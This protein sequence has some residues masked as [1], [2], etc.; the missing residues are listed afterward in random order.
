VEN[1]FRAYRPKPPV[2]EFVEVFWLYVGSRPAH[3]RERLLPMGTMEL[4][5]NLRE[6]EL[7]VGDK[8][9]VDRFRTYGRSLVSGV[10]TNYFVL[11]TSSRQS[12][13]G[14]HFR[15]GGAFP[16]FKMPV[17]EFRGASVSLESIWGRS[18]DLLREALLET[19]SPQE[20]FHTLERFLLARIAKPLERHPAAAHALAKFRQ[21]PLADLISDVAEE[22]G[23]SQRRFI[24]VFTEEVGVSPKLFHRI[25]RFQK[26]LRLMEK[27]ETGILDI[28]LT[29]GFYDQAHFIKEFRAF[30]GL[31]P[32]A[33]LVQRS[34]HFNHVP[35]RS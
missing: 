13:M 19:D 8:G 18:A 22:V 24:Q 21:V 1:L 26:A 9:E 35:I 30:S 4:V 20:K 14:V 3:V 5:I 31:T 33:Y 7:R 12:V 15:P 28:A 6:E 29:C 27:R 34:D 25:Q 23:L 32:T 16:F 11:D 17:S 2:A 10:H